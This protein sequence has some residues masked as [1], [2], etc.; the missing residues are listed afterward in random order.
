MPGHGSNLVLSS[1]ALVTGS[2]ALGT[3][4]DALVTNEFGP[5]SRNE[6][7][8]NEELSTWGGLNSLTG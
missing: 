4:S 1:T 5:M 7:S 8:V 2:D 6:D 3:G